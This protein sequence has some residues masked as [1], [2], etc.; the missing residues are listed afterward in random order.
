MVDSND[1]NKMQIDLMKCLQTQELKLVKEDGANRY[2]IL[3]G[4]NSG[5][6]HEDIVTKQNKDGTVSFTSIK[7][8]VQLDSKL[9]TFKL[10]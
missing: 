9:L 5:L 7:G 4:D 6:K 3:S 10:V 2:I 1:I 8:T